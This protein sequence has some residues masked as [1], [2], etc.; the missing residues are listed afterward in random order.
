MGAWIEITQVEQQHSISMCRTPRWVRGLKSP[1]GPHKPNNF[2]VAP[3]DGCVDWN[4]LM[5]AL[6]NIQS[7]RTPRWVR[8]LKYYCL[9]FVHTNS[10]VAPHDG[11][12]DWNHFE[13][14]LRG[15]RNC[16]IPRW[17]RG[18]KSSPPAIPVLLPSSHPTMG[19]WIEIWCCHIILLLSRSHPTMGAWIEIYST[20]NLTPSLVS[21]PTMGAWIEID[22]VGIVEKVANGRTP[23]WVRGLK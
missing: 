19:A 16:R 15:L 21:H 4:S 12:V 7:C 23:R 2:D 14:F 9:A 10:M 20:E 11:C 3:H 17:V 8:G 18:L 1:R 22:H 13:T 6:G 5:I